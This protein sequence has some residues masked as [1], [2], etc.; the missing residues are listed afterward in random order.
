VIFYRRLVATD[1]PVNIA[2]LH[3]LLASRVF[4]WNSFCRGDFDARYGAET[5]RGETRMSGRMIAAAH[6]YLETRALSLHIHITIWTWTATF[7]SQIRWWLEC[8]CITI[9]Y[10]RCIYLDGPAWH[11]YLVRHSPREA[12]ERFRESVASVYVCELYWFFDFRLN[13]KEGGTVSSG[14]QL[15]YYA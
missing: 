10:C 12:E 1:R 9:L 3:H 2:L 6:R 7:A 13:T 14:L 5:P 4:R 8:G 15:L 11:L